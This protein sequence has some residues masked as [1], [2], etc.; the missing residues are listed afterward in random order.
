[1]VPQ[2]SRV[3][4]HFHEVDLQLF[5]KNLHL[6]SSQISLQKFASTKKLVLIG[7]NA[8]DFLNYS[9]IPP[10]CFI[11]S[12]SYH[13]KLCF[14]KPNRWTISFAD[15]STVCLI[16]ISFVYGMYVNM[17]LIVW[18]WN[19]ILALADFLNLTVVSL[20]DVMN[21]VLC[22]CGMRTYWPKGKNLT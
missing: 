20:T 12:T 17:L 4:L 21:S 5:F 7:K 2:F 8:T 1:M 3:I 15:Y 14:L 19:G 22:F 10:K 16:N 13:I 18:I 11:L 6:K 9:F